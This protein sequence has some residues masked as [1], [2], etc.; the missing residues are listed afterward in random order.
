MKEKYSGNERE[1]MKGRN[2]RHEGVRRDKEGAWGDEK[3]PGGAEK[4]LAKSSRPEK[5]GMK[6]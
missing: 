1:K 4:L 2:A 5:G 3:A 6:R